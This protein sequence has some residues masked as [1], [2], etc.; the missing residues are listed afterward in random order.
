MKSNRGFLR[1]MK[2]CVRQDRIRNKDLRN[3]LGVF[4]RNEKNRQY[5]ENWRQH[6]KKMSE[7]CMP[8]K[9][10]HIQPKGKRDIGK[11]KL[12]KCWRESS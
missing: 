4:E 10:V 11:G 5:K 12:R 3:E 8:K 9:M 1:K 7:T 6:L 2:D